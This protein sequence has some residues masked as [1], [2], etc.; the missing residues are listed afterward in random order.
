MAERTSLLIGTV[1]IVSALCAFAAVR[2]WFVPVRAAAANPATLTVATEPA[3][4]ELLIDSQPRGTTPQTL[5]IAPGPH[6]VLVRTNGAERTLRL[7]LGSGAQ[8]AQYLDLKPNPPAD[9][10]SRGR[11]SIVTDPPGARVAVDGRP[12]GVSPLVIEDLA[13]AAHSVSVTSDTG[14]AQR[15][16]TVADGTTKEVV[17]SLP[18]SQAPLGGWVTV[19]SPFPVDVIEHDE[20]IGTS[21]T[22]RT[23]LAA[24]SHD[25]VLRNDSV[26][27]EA[28]HRI[29]VPAGGVA[30]LEVVPPK[31]S[32][33]VNARPWA[34]VLVDGVSVGQTPLANLML[35]V[36][37]HQMTFRHP[38][39]GE[40]R[41]NVLV[42]A[43]SVNRVA[44]DLS[45]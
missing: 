21:G 19:T 34:D 40:R 13:P 7:S 5:T 20:V 43:K 38:Q 25:V 12:R 27:Y 11:L 28:H 17:F 33:N 15:T 32:V 1:A 23:M 9:V 10:A 37:T 29:D 26:G 14:S 31:G 4:A 45:K 39:L 6:T 41:E 8:M 22:A 18:R 16:I 44:V 35:P 2:V 36:G 30:T 24:G 42:S 3:G